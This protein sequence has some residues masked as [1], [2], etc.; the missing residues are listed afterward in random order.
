VS[1]LEEEEEEEEEGW[2]GFLLSKMGQ[3][4]DAAQIPYWSTEKCR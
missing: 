3:R 1:T 4:E 2:G